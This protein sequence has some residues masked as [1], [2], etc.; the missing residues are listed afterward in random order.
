[1]PSTSRL[2]PLIKHKNAAKT[3]RP[4]LPVVREEPRALTQHAKSPLE[5][6]YLAGVMTSHSQT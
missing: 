6:D 3:C 1:M 2:I 5:V 4:A